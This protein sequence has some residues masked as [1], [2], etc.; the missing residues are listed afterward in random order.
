MEGQ[1]FTKAVRA[2]V[3]EKNQNPWDVQLG[4]KVAQPVKAGD[5][6]L[7][8]VYVK[9][10]ASRAESGEERGERDGDGREADQSLQC[11]IARHSGSQYCTVTSGSI[12]VQNSH[13]GL[14]IHIISHLRLSLLDQ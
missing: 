12:S 7:A 8:T 4:L 3:R 9:A 14:Q 2:E 11:T 10:E 6:I 1:P 13:S 5:V